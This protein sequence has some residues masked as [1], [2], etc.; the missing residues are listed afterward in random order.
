MKV[1]NTGYN[2]CHESNFH[3]ERP[4]GVGEY[5]LLIIRSPARIVLEGENRYIKGNNVILYHKDTPQYFYG[6][7]ATFVNDWVQFDMDEE[8]L[9]FVRDMGIPFDTITGFADVQPLS[10]L[11]KLLYTERWSHYPNAEETNTLLMRLLI[12]KLADLISTEKKTFTTLSDK[13]KRLRDN[14]FT[15]PNQDWSVATI[16]KMIGISPS[17]LHTKYKQQFGT[18]IKNDVITSR[19]EYSKFMLKN[20]KSP[21]IS[22]A[23]QSGYENELQFMC[24]FK[25]KT[26]MTPSQYRKSA[27]TTLG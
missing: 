23:H 3:A 16:A 12:L 10:L 22:I 2:N 25:K 1:S 18:T 26:G 7:N 14:I 11:V 4:L 9:S 6:H 19:L 15:S 24:I 13:I 5:L 20:T 27:T 8:E 17:Y 21:I